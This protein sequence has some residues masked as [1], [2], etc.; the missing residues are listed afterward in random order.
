MSQAP[1]FHDESGTVRFWVQVDDAWVGG[2]IRRE[3]LHYR[4]R[5]EAHDEDPM[6]TFSAHLPD[7]EEAVR[8]RLASGSA[9][10]VMLREH[11]LRPSVA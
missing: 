8:R 1:F 4:F 5:P 10:P 7:I 6:E 2:M 9:E 11:D 3:T